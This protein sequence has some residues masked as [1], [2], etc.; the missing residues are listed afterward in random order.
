MRSGAR[1]G[2]KAAWAGITFAHAECGAGSGRAE[3]VV[4]HVGIYR[5]EITWNGRKIGP[6]ASAGF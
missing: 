5:R 1:C 2:R 3:G 4:C 6:A